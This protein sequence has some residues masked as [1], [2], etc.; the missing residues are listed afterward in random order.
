MLANI[1]ATP[2]KLLAP[3]LCSHLDNAGE[4]VLSGLLQ[5]QAV[6]IAGTYAPWVELNVADSEDGWLLMTGSLRPPRV[7]SSAR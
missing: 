4:L 5:R 1:L 3:L 2:L 6:D 7:A